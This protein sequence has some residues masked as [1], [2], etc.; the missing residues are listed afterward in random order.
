LGVARPRGSFQMSCL[1]PNTGLQRLVG[2]RYKTV[3]PQCTTCFLF[4]QQ[5]PSK[6]QCSLFLWSPI[7][8]FFLYILYFTNFI[9]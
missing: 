3:F 8:N 4:P 7:F 6:S 9:C 5:C 2:M 1:S